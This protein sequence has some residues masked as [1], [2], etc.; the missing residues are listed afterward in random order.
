MVRRAEDEWHYIAPGKPIQNG[1]VER[2][3]GRMRD[4]FL[5]ETLF[6]NIAHAR[7][8]IAE[9]VI[10]YN[11]ERQHS[12][13]GYQTPADFAL[14]L[15]TAI[16]RPAAQ[17]ESSARWVNAQHTPKGVNDQRASVAAG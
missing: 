11:T 12:A 3:N 5:K 16:T 13:L 15:A 8:L 6:R 7:I 2:F 17:H 1:C 10:D 14:H 9:W 4:E